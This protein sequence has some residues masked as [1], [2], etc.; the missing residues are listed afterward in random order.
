MTK[1][2]PR[3]IGPF[4]VVSKKGLAYMLNVSRKLR[5]YPVFYVRLLN[6]YLNSSHVIV[7]VLAPRKLALKSVAA[8]ESGDQAEPPSGPIPTPMPGYGLDATPTSEHGL[9]S[10][11]AHS[12]SYSMSRG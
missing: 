9:A 2:R 6:L 4:T 5:T 10:R 8:S 12:G 3:V 1:L 7:E 11:R